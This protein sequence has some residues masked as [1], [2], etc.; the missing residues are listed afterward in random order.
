MFF[1]AFHERLNFFDG[2]YG[3][4]IHL[5][6]K[7]QRKSLYSD[8]CSSVFVQV[9]LISKWLYSKV[10]HKCNTLKIFQ[11][12][13][14]TVKSGF[15]WIRKMTFFSSRFTQLFFRP[16]SFY[17]R[18]AV[19]TVLKWSSWFLASKT[20]KTNVLWKYNSKKSL[21][22]GSSAVPRSYSEKDSR[23]QGNKEGAHQNSKVRLCQAILHIS[24][25]SSCWESSDDALNHYLQRETLWQWSQCT[26]VWKTEKRI[27]PIRSTRHCVMG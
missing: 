24:T 8:F 5:T 15:Q 27:E 18:I 2:K 23:L 6:S 9:P 21:V 26:K 25:H 19:G 17:T 16:I 10:R 7:S 11:K 22:I 4:S 20:S 13:L 12:P 3:Y 14:K 1:F